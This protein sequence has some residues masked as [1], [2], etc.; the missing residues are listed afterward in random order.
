MSNLGRLEGGLGDVVDGAN[1]GV[2]VASDEVV[3]HGS[4]EEGSGSGHLHFLG[5]GKS[6]F[7]KLCLIKKILR[8]YNETKKTRNRLTLDPNRTAVRATGRAI[9]E[10]I[11][12]IDF[13]LE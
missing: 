6:V 1:A 9:R 13:S 12:K 7:L 2:H 8:L 10:S 11:L 3:E 4:E 5:N